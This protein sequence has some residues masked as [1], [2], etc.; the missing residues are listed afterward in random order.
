MRTSEQKQLQEFFNETMI[1]AVVTGTTSRSE[2]CQRLKISD[3]ELQNRIDRQKAEIASGEFRKKH[4]PGWPTASQMKASAEKALTLIPDSFSFLF[5]DYEFVIMRG[6]K[7]EELLPWQIILQSLYTRIRFYISDYV[8][9][10]LSPVSSPK[11]PTSQIQSNDGSS[12]DLMY[13]A[14]WATGN[15]NP[16]RYSPMPS[17]YDPENYSYVIKAMLDEL[18][19]LLLKNAE[20]FLRGD[21]SKWDELKSYV[22]DLRYG[23]TPRE[24]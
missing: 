1:L 9:I 16:L 4:G 11:L 10:D 14:A 17:D 23:R 22:E 3:E 15:S 21:F 6:G 18:A 13:I 2:A 19:P 12:I 24:R 20:P 8:T 7:Y 5:K